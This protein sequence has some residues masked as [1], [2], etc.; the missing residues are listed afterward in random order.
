MR[1][2]PQGTNMPKN[3]FRFQ[4]PGHEKQTVSPEE[5]P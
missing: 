5:L 1:S 4:T 2:E 3:F